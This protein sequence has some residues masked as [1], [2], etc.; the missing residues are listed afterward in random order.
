MIT[1]MSQHKE[2][3]SAAAMG[4]EMAPGEQSDAEHFQSWANNMLIMFEKTLK[5]M[6]GYC[7]DAMQPMLQRFESTCSSMEKFLKEKDR[8]PKR[9]K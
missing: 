3:V 2:N 9:I 6:P 5:S 4:A 8:S 7:A 1:E